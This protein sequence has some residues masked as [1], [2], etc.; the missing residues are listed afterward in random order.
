[1]VHQPRS[2]AI[3]IPSLHGL[4]GFAALL[5]FW[6]H[7]RWKAGDPEIILAGFD[8]RAFLQ[9]C[10][11][12]VCIFF[13]LSGYLLANG[14]RPWVMDASE[15]CP[16]PG[17]SR[18]VVRRAAR[19]LPLYL[20]VLLTF[21][22]FEKSTY[23]F[24]GIV[25]LVLHVFCLH[26]FFQYSYTSINPV[27]WTIGI[28]FQFYLLL[29]LGM[30]L[31]RRLKMY[32]GLWASLVCLVALGYGGHLL[33]QATQTAVA[34]FVPDKLLD[35]SNTPPASVFY[36]LLWFW[37]GIAWNFV[38]PPSDSEYKAGLIMEAGFLMSCLA[39]IALII[40]SV[41]GQWRSISVW[42]WPLNCLVSGMLITTAS[43]SRLGFLCF[44]NVPMRR[45]GDLSFGLYL[46]HWPIMSAVF[47]G[48]LPGRVGA[49]AALLVCGGL[50][51]IITLCLSLLTFYLV[52]QPAIAWGRK[53]GSIRDIC[54]SVFQKVLLGLS[55]R[56]L[57]QQS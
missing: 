31:V 39:L 37:V 6:Y 23:A 20:V 49:T 26:T 41:E 21:T 52:E 5:V 8:L 9:H 56:S 13:V 3:E 17:F 25:D 15:S 19:I 30:L 18:Y 1:M 10:D 32:I 36:F 53:H 57:P 48:T 16:R 44:E 47:A 29:P 51:L 42:G 24:Y 14:F 55:S 35:A 28:E 46:W 45:L 54:R 2:Q 50:S 27:L 43:R 40:Q 4:R 22:L 33:F 12:G 7:A 38:F 11:V 34:P